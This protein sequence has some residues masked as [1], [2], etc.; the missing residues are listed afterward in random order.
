MLSPYKN[1]CRTRNKRK[2][3]EDNNSTT[4]ETK[5][6][7]GN[8]NNPLDKYYPIIIEQKPKNKNHR[9]KQKE[10]EKKR[11]YKKTWTIQINK[12]GA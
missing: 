5:K 3:P 10:K 8:T 9:I 7:K 12:S 11:I 1:R 4:Q 6:K 2:S